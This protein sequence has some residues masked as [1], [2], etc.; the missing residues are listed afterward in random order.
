MNYYNEIKSLIETKEINTKVRNIE[1]NNNTLKTYYEIGRLL[2]KAQGGEKRAKYGDNLIKKW[3]I[4]LSNE[5]G[6]G[7]S[8]ANLKNMRKFYVL[9]KKS[10]T[11]CSQLNLS[12]SHY[13][14]LLKFND[15]NERNYYINRCIENNLSVRD[16]INEIKTD[17]FER[18]TIKDKDNIK[19]ITENDNKKTTLSDML[20][21]PIIINANNT[22]NVN[23]KALK[24]YILKELEHFF[25]EL[26]FGFTFV[27]C[28]YKIK[29]GSN[30]Y[31]ID[32]LLYNVRLNCYVVIELKKRNLLPKDIGQIEFYMNY[33]DKCVKESF[34]NK[35][36]GIIICK[37]NNKLICKYISNKDINIINYLLKE[38]VETSVST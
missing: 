19:L 12:W 7:Y 4:K 15:E 38:K 20:K 6:K 18:S 21:N 25:L 17:S 5:Y 23:E 13:K 31:F 33:I 28:E 35:T 8:F 3:S 10:Y 24:K 29:I 27:A 22:N 34:N 1:E 11:V 16:L 9:F 32:L 2:V 14:Y 26:G 36:E 37:E 30:N